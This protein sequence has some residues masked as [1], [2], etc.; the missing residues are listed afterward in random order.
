[1]VEDYH[2]KVREIYMPRPTPDQTLVPEIN[3]P[4]PIIHSPNP[5]STDP[6]SE[7]YNIPQT[8]SMVRYTEPVS[9][10]ARQ[11]TC[12][13][14]GFI[15]IFCRTNQPRSRNITCGSVWESY[16]DRHKH[17][18]GSKTLQC[19]EFFLD[20]ANWGCWW[21]YFL[22]ASVCQRLVL[23][24]HHFQGQASSHASCP[25]NCALLYNFRCLH[26]KAPVT[27]AVG[28]TLKYIQK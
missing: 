18:T 8:P 22:Y 14:S 12:G 21:R 3:Q 20:L 4:R 1:M 27:G 16:L 6:A 25:S 15:E 13:W 26:D 11:G 23:S 24:L 10:S 2:M 7:T 9:K 17:R 5:P 19:R 28:N